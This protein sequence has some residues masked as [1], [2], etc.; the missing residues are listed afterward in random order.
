MIK[1][2]H[3]LLSVALIGG[4]STCAAEPASSTATSDN[5]TADTT[6]PDN[7]ARVEAFIDGY[8]EGKLGA[9]FQ[10]DITSFEEVK[11]DYEVKGVLSPGVRAEAPIS[12]TM[13][14]RDQMDSLTVSDSSF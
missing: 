12:F 10:I 14:V 1:L 3:L 4:L 2:N 6:A 8:A 5:A 11:G 7:Q 9:D 13:T